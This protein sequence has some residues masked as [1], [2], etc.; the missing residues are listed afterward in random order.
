M[1]MPGPMMEMAVSPPDPFL[2]AL[3]RVEM[4]AGAVLAG[5]LNRDIT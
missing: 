5:L 3:S 1:F 2:A 4:G